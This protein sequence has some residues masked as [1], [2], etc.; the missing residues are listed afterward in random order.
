MNVIFL[1]DTFEKVCEI[2][3]GAF[4]KDGGYG[5]DKLVKAYFTHPTTAKA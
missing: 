5:Y 4:D 3:V 2:A 1:R